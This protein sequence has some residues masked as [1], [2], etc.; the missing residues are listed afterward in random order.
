MILRIRPADPALAERLLEIQHRAYAVEAELIGFDGI[1]PLQEDLAALTA[2]TEHWLGCFA[3]DEL[4]GAVAYEL[5]DDET[6]EIS[7]LVVD[8][9]YARQGHG[10]ALLDALDDLEPRATSLVSTGTAN[11]PAATL[12]LGRGYQE[13]GRTEVA[14]GVW[15][16]HFRRLRVL[17]FRTG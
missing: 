13:T 9:A 3:G 4:V 16:T 11:T 7:R 15:L 14:P 8:P 1:P 5:P 6:V 10:R 17:R 12:Y 2:S